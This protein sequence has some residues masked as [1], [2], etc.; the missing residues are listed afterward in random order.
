MPELEAVEAQRHE[1]GSNQVNQTLEATFRERD[2]SGEIGRMKKIL[3]K[4]STIPG[5]KRNSGP[6]S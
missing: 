1:T 4:I 6:R 3:T 5:S 2:R